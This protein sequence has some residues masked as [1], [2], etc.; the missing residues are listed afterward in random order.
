MSY[1]ALH[2]KNIK[3][4]VPVDG[5]R[6]VRE[7]S[8]TIERWILKGGSKFSSNTKCREGCCSIT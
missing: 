5:V 1:V 2:G 4:I 3:G 6:V 8:S 7:Y